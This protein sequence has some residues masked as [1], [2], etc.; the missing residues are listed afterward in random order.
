MKYRILVEIGARIE[1]DEFDF[2]VI[3]FER[4]ESEGEDKRSAANAVWD[5]INEWT[6]KNG[7]ADRAVYDRRVYA[8]PIG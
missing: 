3:D 2:E 8:T 7:Y 1:D 4:W 5:K 6:S